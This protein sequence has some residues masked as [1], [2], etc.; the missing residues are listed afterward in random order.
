[1]NACKG[2]VKTAIHRNVTPDKHNGDGM[3]QTSEADGL[4]PWVCSSD[5]HDCVGYDIYT[6]DSVHK[7]KKKAGAE[8]YKDCKHWEHNE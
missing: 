2:L 6:A 7:T 3:K 5:K 1:M 8:V 4:E